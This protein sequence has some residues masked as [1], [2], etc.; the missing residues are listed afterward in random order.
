MT[1][2]HPVLGWCLVLGLEK[3]GLH[4]I[5]RNGMWITPL[6]WGS[7]LDCSNGSWMDSEDP[8]RIRKG[9]TVLFEGD[10]GTGLLKR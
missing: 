5:Q 6:A 7:G 3:A 2:C 8:Q 9:G 4:S 1:G 10:G